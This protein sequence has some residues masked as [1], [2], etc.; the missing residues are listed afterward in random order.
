MSVYNVLLADPPWEYS[1]RN[2]GGSMKSGAAQQYPT[3]DLE[4]IKRMWRILHPL[5]APGGC[6]LFLW[7]TTPLKFEAGEVMR[8]W[9]F[10]YKT[11][12][13]WDKDRMGMGFWLRGQVEELLVG[14]RGDVKPFRLQEPNII[15]E[16]PMKHSRKPEESYR[17]IQRALP[18]ARRLELFATEKRRGWDSWGNVVQNDV[19]LDIES[20]RVIDGQ[21]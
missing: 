6:V 7:A 20:L 21:G 2:T 9:G 11:T 4:T 18:Y 1:N 8:A 15:R 13:Y 14:V 17:M 10:E 16:K 3:L 19:H 12:V 5:Y